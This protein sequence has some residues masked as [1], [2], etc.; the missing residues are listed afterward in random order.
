M[1]PAATAPR[2]HRGFH[3]FESCY[4]HQF[5]VYERDILGNVSAQLTFPEVMTATLVYPTG[6]RHHVRFG[7]YETLMIKEENGF[8]VGA[9]RSL[10]VPHKFVT[11]VTTCNGVKVIFDN[12]WYCQNDPY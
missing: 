12:P 1:A 6:E 10:T 3:R 7:Q 2:L 11:N 4:P 8:S 9:V 5:M